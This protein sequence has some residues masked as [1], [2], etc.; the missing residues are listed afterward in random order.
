[1]LIDGS[2]TRSLPSQ[3]DM[4]LSHEYAQAEVIH[5][6]TITFEIKLI[7]LKSFAILV[8]L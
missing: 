8:M 2:V 3:P 4:E 6:M 5:D 1:M 7:F